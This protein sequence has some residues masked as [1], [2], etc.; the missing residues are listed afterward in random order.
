MLVLQICRTFA[1]TGTCPYGT[2]CRFIHQSAALA[3]LRIASAA[4]P[5]GSP[6]A[7]FHESFGVSPRSQDE[8]DH[9]ASAINAVLS[10][11]VGSLGSL[12]SLSPGF[13]RAGS[14]TPLGTSV[15]MMGG[16]CQPQRFSS[17]F[18][19]GLVGQQGGVETP[20]LLSP[21][22][23]PPMGLFVNT[24]PSSAPN[25]PHGN[26]MGQVRRVVSDNS[27]AASGNTAVTPT[28]ARRLPIFSSLA[29]EEIA[30]V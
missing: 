12:R 3:Q 26:M 14:N 22:A 1:T 30:K 17:P 7:S 23:S 8:R 29:E 19:S 11:S 4:T 13:P 20:G 5:N 6:G 28:S 9:V 16:A 2:R 25:T 21:V 15:G 24:T 27:L 18:L 10:P